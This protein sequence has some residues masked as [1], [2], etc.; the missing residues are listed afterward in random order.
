MSSEHPHPSAANEVYRLPPPLF[1]AR[2][3][4]CWFVAALAVL[5]VL[6]FWSLDLQWARFFAP[7]AIGRMGRF[8]AELLSPATDAKFLAK[9]VPATL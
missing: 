6:S 2:C 5:I 9:L 8:L 1:S 4:A 7:D 3:R